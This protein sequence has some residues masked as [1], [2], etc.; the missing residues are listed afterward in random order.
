MDIGTL[1]GLRYLCISSK[2]EIFGIK[3]EIKIFLFKCYIQVKY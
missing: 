1:K 2:D 3:L